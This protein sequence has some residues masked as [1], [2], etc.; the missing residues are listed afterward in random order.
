MEDIINFCKC[1]FLLILRRTKQIEQDLSFPDSN[2]TVFKKAFESLGKGYDFKFD[3]SKYHTMSCTEFVYYCGMEFF[4]KYNVKLKTRS[5]LFKKMEMLI[6]DDFVT[7]EFEIAFQSASIKQ[8]KLD[9]ILA[10][11]ASE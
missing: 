6:P 9:A 8:A 5:V 7:K 10:K 2:K 3:F 4:E 1:D 11:N